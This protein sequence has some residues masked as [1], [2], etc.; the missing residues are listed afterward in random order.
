MKAM[1]REQSF[2]PSSNEAS[3]LV[4]TKMRHYMN[5]KANKHGLYYI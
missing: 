1:E 2:G 4:A 3:F 5:L